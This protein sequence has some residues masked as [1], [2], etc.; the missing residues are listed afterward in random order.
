PAEAEDLPPA[1]EPLSATEPARD[2]QPLEE[3]LE[4][5]AEA[6]LAELP[7]PPPGALETEPNDDESRADR[8]FPGVPRVGT[9]PNSND[10]DVYR[11]FLA[12]DQPVRVELVPPE[13]GDPLRFD[14]SEAGRF[15]PERDAEPGTPN[16]AELWLKAGDHYVTVRN[17]ETGD[18]WYQLRLTLL[19]GAMPW[20]EEE[21]GPAAADG[22]VRIELAADEEAV[23]AFIPYGQEFTVTAAV[24][25]TASTAQ[26]VDLTAHVTDAR[27]Q[28]EFP[29]SLELDAGETAEVPITV[30]T[31]DDLRS[32]VPVELSLAA[33]TGG[34]SR[35]ATLSI[36]ARCMAQP[37]NPY[38]Y[39]PVP[40]PLLGGIDV[41]WDGLGAEFHHE[42]SRGR[43]EP[44]IDGRAS[45][46]V[47][48]RILP[49]DPPE[50]RLAGDEPVELTGA[51]LHPL[52]RSGISD[53]LNGFRIETSLD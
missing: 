48:P 1:D 27:I 44:L 52:N 53:Q 20:D 18:G 30:T 40:E 14:L 10:T 29:D 7:P 43:P 50:F 35:G 45:P 47:N 36:D 9:L 31:P 22:P 13:N 19:N 33:T 8:I 11:F 23:A 42:P 24:E 32:D 16:V 15:L 6:E 37:L 39:W 28:L 25:N 46:A 5:P 2:V 38:W 49:D 34:G 17:G 12:E 26:T 3:A 4:N 21:D 41:A 51:L